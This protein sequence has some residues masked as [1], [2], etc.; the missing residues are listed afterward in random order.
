M[1]DYRNLLSPRA[2]MPLL[3]YLRSIGVVQQPLTPVAATPA[4]QLLQDYRRHLLHE[5]CLVEGT[6]RGSEEVA[7][8]FLD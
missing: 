3:E 6:V 2:L 8:R 1:A 7:R 5:R 4:A